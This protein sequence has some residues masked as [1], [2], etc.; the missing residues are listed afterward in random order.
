MGG[1]YRSAAAIRVVCFEAAVLLRIR[2]SGA[3]AV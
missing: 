2:R 3:T 1:G